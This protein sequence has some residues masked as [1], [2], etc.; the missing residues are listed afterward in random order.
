M[1]ISRDITTRTERPDMLSQQLSKTSFFRI[2]RGDQRFVAVML[3]L[4]AIAG[5]VSGSPQVAMWF[6]FALAAY[7]AI[8]NDSIQTLG[9][10]LASNSKRTWVWQ[11]LFMGGIFAAT[12]LYSWLSY[13]GDVSHERLMSKG[14]EVAPTEFSFL[15]LAAPIFLLILTR[16]KM[17]VS[18]S[19]LLLSCFATSGK[20]IVAMTSK[21]LGGY[22]IAFLLSIVIWYAFEPAMNRAWKGKASPIWRPIQW[23]ATGLLW[24][25]WLMQDMANIAVFLPRG[26][27]AGPGLSVIELSA[28]IGVIFL[29]LGMLFYKRGE[30]IQEVVN[31]KK[32]VGDVRSATLIVIVYALILY[33]FKIHS[34]VPMSTTWVFIGLLAG[35]EIAFGIR[36]RVEAAGDQPLRAARKMIFKDLRA[37]TIGFVVSLVLAATINPVIRDA[38]FK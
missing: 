23:V 32:G 34:K 28:F 3:A 16:L 33:V 14:F 6:G 1:S 35:R 24:S 8:A 11:W 5:S 4:F 19:F 17:P 13:G 12:T 38:L 9:T 21:S 26:G 27:E 18:T 30:A 29:G 25:V 15:Q 37:V 2:S 31:E 7:S 22:V 20:G 36:R 10:F